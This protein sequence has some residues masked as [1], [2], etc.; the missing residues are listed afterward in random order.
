MAGNGY[1]FIVFGV[2]FFYGRW[3]ERGT[4]LICMLLGGLGE[5]VLSLWWRLYDYQF[6]NLPLFVPPGHAL[7]ML[8]GVLIAQRLDIIFHAKDSLKTPYFQ[9]F[10]LLGVP[11]IA[12]AYTV[13]VMHTGND[14]FGALLFLVFL[15]CMVFGRAKTLYV[16]MFLLA[17]LMELYGT[18]LENSRLSPA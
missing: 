14:I 10:W 13:W 11:L 18:T 1:A 17:L 8:L 7:L 3:T 4:L 2:L 16:T 6:G 5:A 9:A 15:A 12:L